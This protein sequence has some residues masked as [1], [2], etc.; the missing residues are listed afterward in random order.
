[1]RGFMRVAVA[2]MLTSLT[3]LGLGAGPVA[4]A[5]ADGTWE[6]TGSV[7]APARSLT[8]VAVS[9][10]GSMQ[11]TA[12]LL[13]SVSQTDSCDDTHPAQVI[14]ALQNTSTQGITPITNGGLALTPISSPGVTAV[15]GNATVAPGTYAL[16]LRFRCT[17]SGTWNGNV[18]PTPAVS[19]SIASLVS[20]AY[21]TKAC[22]ST[23]PVTECGS[24]S[25]PATSVPQGTSV[26]FSG[27]IRRS[28]TDGV[29]T[30]SAVDGSQTLKRAD[31]GTSSWSTMSSSCA[32]TT[33][34]T[35]SGQ[36]RCESTY[37]THDAVTVTSMAPTT[38]YFIGAPAPSPALALKGSAITV[39]GIIQMRYPD[40]SQWP[41]PIGTGFTVQVQVE[42]SGSW[43]NVDSGTVTTLGNYSASFNLPG[44]GKVRI[45]AGTY[46][47]AEAAVT[48]LKSTGSYEIAAPTA[49]TTVAPRT[50]TTMSAN[51]K[52]L[53]S[54]S[55]F[56]D[57]PDGTTA[58]LQFAEAHEPS[59]APGVWRN[60][61]TV[62]TAGGVATFSV[63]P[64]AS[65]LWRVSVNGQ[66]SPTTF[67]TV[68]GSAPLMLT[69]TLTPKAGQWPFVDK[70]AVYDATAR[71]S[72]YVGSEPTT[73]YVA[74]DGTSFSKVG[75]LTGDSFAGDI[76]IRAPSAPGSYAPAWQLRNPN[77][78]VL[79]T[80]TSRAVAV[81]GVKA[82]EVVAEPTNDVL[83]EG[84]SG[85]ITGSV[86]VVTLAG[87][88]FAGTWSGSVALQR[89]MGQGWSTIDS[90]NKA[91]GSE[92][93]F[94]TPAVKGAEYR[95][96]W[97]TQNAASNVVQLKVVTPTGQMRFA[98]VY[99]EDPRLITGDST[100]LVA[101]V[102][103]EYSDGEFYPAPA[104]ERVL[105]QIGG[106]SDWKTVKT[107]YTQG[108]SVRVSVKPGATTSYRFVLSTSVSSKAITVSVTEA[109][110]VRIRIDWPDSYYFSE[111]GEFTGYIETNAGTVWRGT[112][113]LQLHYRYAGESSWRLLDT[114]TYK[115]KRFSWGWGSGPIS[116][117]TFRV[118][119]PAL[120]LENA[121]RYSPDY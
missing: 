93:D 109:R 74:I 45:S 106:G 35:S 87:Q 64:Q 5:P 77:G 29:I 63:V 23:T 50:A 11:V 104:G 117:V 111:G 91:S 78:D 113:V 69:A 33:T 4:A 103:V 75:V 40:A 89:S 57:A 67:V 31:V 112:T 44:T 62:S 32:Y 18:A 70:Y 96:L 47:S 86:T 100:R 59:A 110:P 61:Q 65:G 10:A 25:P 52:S 24:V 42:G 118:S 107:L 80:A 13:T 82:Y 3:S 76:R 73:L 27:L 66:P 22:L 94:A 34:I 90:L 54:D 49:P 16:I 119:A 121:N 79:V 108:G 58:T 2:V 55:T 7:S 99:A 114:G 1:M 71:L 83:R 37:G 48:E 20:T 102:Q 28:W 36:Y 15:T 21:V 95:L 105:L 26:T 8:N 6:F 30:D 43:T 39:R 98:R 53:W 17:G 68:T 60:T 92:I 85:R 14:P 56:R 51:V 97:T 115:G 12:G 88:R 81:D 120:G 46:L 19:V 38:D 84:Q 101:S 72:G 9:V 41:A 116:A